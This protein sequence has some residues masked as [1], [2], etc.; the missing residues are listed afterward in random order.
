[1]PSTTFDQRIEDCET[2]INQARDDLAVLVRDA[3]DDNPNDNDNDRMLQLT[4][5]IGQLERRRAALVEAQRAQA[6]SGRAEGR[7]PAD[8]SA[9]NGRGREL[10]PVYVPNRMGVDPLKVSASEIAIRRADNSI[11]WRAPPAI[12]KHKKEL[13]PVD[14]LVRNGVV[15][16]LAHKTRKPV[17]EVLL[18]TYGDDEGTR[19]VFNA[20]Q[21]A[22]TASAMTDVAGGRPNWLSRFTPTS[23]I[24]LCPC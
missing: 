21:R 13:D 17:E 8:P 12:I 14:Y 3:D 23:C 22:A 6:P 1:M 9:G 20:I 11:K 18:R 5:R 2:A 7:D 24:R 19:A 15:M 4:Q 10:V 16:L